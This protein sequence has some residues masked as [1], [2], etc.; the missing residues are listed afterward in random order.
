MKSAQTRSSRWIPYVV[1]GIVANFFSQ[2]AYVVGQQVD[3]V[4]DLLVTWGY[5]QLLALERIT[6]GLLPR[7]SGHLLWLAAYL[8]L[9]ALA[10]LA[11]ERRRIA[12]SGSPWARAFV[13]WLVLILLS[14]LMLWALVASGMLVD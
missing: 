13:A 2:A 4:P 7:W 1:I 6:F 3:W 10:C 12:T 9:G 14:A 8:A 5:A 11:L